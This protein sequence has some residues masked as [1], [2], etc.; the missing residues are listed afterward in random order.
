L[1]GITLKRT[2]KRTPRPI[3][4]ENCPVSDDS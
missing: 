2:P 1:D 3:N 4:V